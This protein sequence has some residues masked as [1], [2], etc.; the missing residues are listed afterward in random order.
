M[1]QW[2]DLIPYPPSDITGPLGDWLRNVVS[3]LNTKVARASYFS[4]LSPNG[5]GLTAL[6]GYL[7][8]NMSPSQ[9]TDSRVWVHG[10]TGAGPSQGGYVVLRT[11]A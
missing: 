4:G 2:P 5:S 8:I 6:P 11:L 7:A 10:G 1:S 9:S 3:T